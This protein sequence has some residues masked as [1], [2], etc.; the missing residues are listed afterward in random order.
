M[1]SYLPGNGELKS[2]CLMFH[3]VAQR[4]RVPHAFVYYAVSIPKLLPLFNKTAFIQ[5]VY[6]QSTIQLLLSLI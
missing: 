6:V 2:Y 5:D 1:P 4:A 3:F